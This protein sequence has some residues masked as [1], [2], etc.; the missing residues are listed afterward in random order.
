L[1]TVECRERLQQ[2]LRRSEVPGIHTFSESCRLLDAGEKAVANQQRARG[3]PMWK[4]RIARR[5]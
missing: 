3:R 2:T 1:L 5:P 4:V